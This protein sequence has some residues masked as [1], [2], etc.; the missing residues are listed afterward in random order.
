M[1]SR[2]SAYALEA[3]IIIAARDGERITAT[4]LAAQLDLPPNYLSKILNAM[5][6]ARVLE[7]ERGP[8][9]GFRLARE[10]AGIAIEDIIGLFEDVGS[11]RRCFLGRGTCS[12]TDSC[13]VH[14]R[15]K[16]VS[17]PMFDFFHETTLESLVADRR[18]KAKAA[19]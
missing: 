1:I 19:R 6:R 9:G 2:T 8:R 7:S 5:A 15:W 10:P 18:R 11:R 13:A 14:D 17:T 16:K 3:A 12:D 4:D